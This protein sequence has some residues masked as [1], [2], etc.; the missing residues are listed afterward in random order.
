MAIVRPV[1]PS[2]LTR[3]LSKGS[4]DANIFHRWSVLQ[5]RDWFSDVCPKIRLR[6]SQESFRFHRF[7]ME[8]ERHLTATN[9]K[10]RTH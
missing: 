9:A 1:L 7:N 8:T 4:F 5:L 3:C 2:R 6:R 10:V